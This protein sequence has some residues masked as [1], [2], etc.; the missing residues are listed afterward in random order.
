[1]RHAEKESVRTLDEVDK[2]Q[3]FLIDTFQ[4]LMSSL[5]VRDS[6]LNIEQALM[7]AEEAR[8]SGEQARRNAW[9]TQLASIYLPLS[10]VTGI[11][12]MNIK[13]M[14]ERKPSF[15]WVI[16]VLVVLVVLTVGI[17]YGLRK[18]EKELERRREAK[19]LVGRG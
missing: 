14:D 4:L 13:E 19:R 11:F 10:V 9:L 5:A 7:S 1:M 12:G 2:L 16:V 8:L 6:R 3:S 18:A 15:W 17:F